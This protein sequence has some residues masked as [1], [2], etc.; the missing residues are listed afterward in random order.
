MR[1]LVLLVY[2][3]A[4]VCW[5]SQKDSSVLLS[6]ALFKLKKW[7]FAFSTALNSSS[8]MTTITKQYCDE[9]NYNYKTHTL[10]KSLCV[11][12]ILF[13]NKSMPQRTPTKFY[14]Q[15]TSLHSLL[16]YSLLL[17]TFI[18]HKRY[19]AYNKAWIYFALPLQG[20]ESQTYI[21]I[22]MGS[23]ATLWFCLCFPQYTSSL[24]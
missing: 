16:V 10:K 20:L 18:K 14:W 7:R 8:N 24:S 3:R 5:G 9:Y 4:C 23:G 22:V 6:F 1:S 12:Q 17:L 21:F 15:M 2:A 13:C 11:Y 19:T